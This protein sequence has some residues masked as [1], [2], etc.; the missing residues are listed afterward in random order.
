MFITREIEYAMRMV[1]ALAD[2]E[3]KAVREICEDERLP[4][5][6]AYKILKKMERANIVKAFYGVNGGYQLN[7]GVAQITMLDILAINENT[8]RFG[9]CAH[10]L[11]CLDDAQS[12]GCVINREFRRLESVVRYQ[13]S[14]RTM[15]DV[16]GARKPKNTILLAAEIVR[17]NDISLRG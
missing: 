11:E 5:K 12:N 14:K 16:I 10:G 4:Q 2:N 7:R 8:L 1:R 6:W 13:L 17:R 15:D 3:V 9:E